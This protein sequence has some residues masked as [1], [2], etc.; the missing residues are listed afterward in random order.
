MR[1]KAVALLSAPQFPHGA[2][3]ID[4]VSK[5]LRKPT[6]RRNLNS[7]NALRL[8]E[9]NP[10]PLSLGQGE[11]AE[12][13]RPVLTTA[14]AIRLTGPPTRY[15]KGSLC[16]P[17]AWLFLENRTNSEK[18]ACGVSRIRVELRDIETQS[19]VKCSG[20]CGS[21]PGTRCASH[22]QPAFPASQATRHTKLIR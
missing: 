7:G 2:G 9:H 8:S 14:R 16:G 1:I 4:C 12:D 5:K 10:A 15:L 11:I 21:R 20:M 17:G 3:T 22:D 19:Q 6:Q 13:G 18:I